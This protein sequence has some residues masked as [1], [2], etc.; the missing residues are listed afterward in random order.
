MCSGEKD[1]KEEW[2]NNVKVSG[3]KWVKSRKGKLEMKD[4]EVEKWESKLLVYSLR[5]VE[6]RLP[7]YI[8][9]A[10][11]AERTRPHLLWLLA[12]YLSL[13]PLPSFDYASVQCV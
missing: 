12:L 2:Y 9:T 4:M 7:L 13:G 5:H 8:N 3:E 11:A 6:H 10:T 1:D